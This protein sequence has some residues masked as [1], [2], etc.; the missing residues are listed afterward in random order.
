MDLVTPTRSVLGDAR[1]LPQ[2]FREQGYRAVKLGKIFHTGVGFEDP[3]SWDEELTETPEAKNP[4]SE[5]IAR[6]E[7]GGVVV[8]EAKDE[9]T[10]DGKLARRGAEAIRTLAAR[11]TPFSRRWFSKTPHPILGP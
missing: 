1:M 9:E 6:K 11:D 5:Q 7:F 8:L 3:R 4:P 10:W 2:Y